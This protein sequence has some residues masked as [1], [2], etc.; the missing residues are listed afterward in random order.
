MIFTRQMSL[1]SKWRTWKKCD[2]QIDGV[3]V[4][5]L[6]IIL[7]VL[8]VTVLNVRE[9]MLENVAH[10][11]LP[12]MDHYLS[13]FTSEGRWINFLLFGGLR[14]VPQVI[15]V[16]LCTAFVGVFGYQVAA[17]MKQ[18]PWLAFCFCLA[19]VNIPYFTMLFKY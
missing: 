9:S 14:D 12:Y 7:S 17:G 6:L 11:A 18:P 16:W 8:V 5:K 4:I 19:M 2:K 3:L 13:K 10:D 1:R 15:A